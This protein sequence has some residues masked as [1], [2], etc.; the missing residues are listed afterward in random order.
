MNEQKPSYTP[1]VTK[2]PDGVYRWVYR[3]SREQNRH[4]L[5]ITLTVVGAMCVFLIGMALFFDREMLWIMLLTCG[6]VMLIAGLVCWIFDRLSRNGIAQ[7]FELTEDHVRWVGHGRTDFIYTFRSIRSVHILP[8]EDIIEI[9]QL[10]GVMQVY[11]PHEDFG[12]V[13]DYI[14]RRV[15]RN[16]NIE[17]D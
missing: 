17:Y 7:P 13:Q 11:V 16:T 4:A 8:Q 10:L 3:I 5:K 12:L 9:R 14:L 2:D 15:G 6:A 1:R